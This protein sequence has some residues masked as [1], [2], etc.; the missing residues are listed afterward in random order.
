MNAQQ[1]MKISGHKDYKS[2]SRYVDVTEQSAKNAMER[3]W[4]KTH[5]PAKKPV[6]HIAPIR[7]IAR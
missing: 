6:K 7:R 4:G 5:K 2:F 3:A 1:V